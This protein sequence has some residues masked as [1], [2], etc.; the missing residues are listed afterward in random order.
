MKIS[1][2]IPDTIQTNM[3]DF[4]LKEHF[5]FSITI[6]SLA[7]TKATYFLCLPPFLNVA[8][9]ILQYTRNRFHIKNTVWFDKVIYIVFVA[10]M[11]K[12]WIVI[13]K[14]SCVPKTNQSY[15]SSYERTTSFRNKLSILSMDSLNV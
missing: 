2:F 4:F 7:V 12:K 15:S 10:A 6:F 3:I 14:E 1:M 11:G 13:N 9:A 8:T 5:Q